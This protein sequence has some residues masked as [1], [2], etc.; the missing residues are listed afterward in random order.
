MTLDE[1]LNRVINQISDATRE[2]NESMAGYYYQ[3]DQTLFRILSGD[4]NKRYRLEKIEDYT[5]YYEDDNNNQYIKVVQ[6]KYH[7][8]KVTNSKVYKP[9]LYGYISYLAFV[10]TNINVNFSMEILIG[11]DI[12]I[13]V[14]KTSSLEGIL[15]YAPFTDSY[16]EYRSKWRENFEGD[17]PRFID[18]Q[19]H[20]ENFM[21]SLSVTEGQNYN[22]LKREI[23]DL[24]KGIH[25]IPRVSEETYYSFYWNI[26]RDYAI[27]HAGEIITKE[28]L[29]DNVNREVDCFIATGDTAFFNSNNYNTYVQYKVAGLISIYIEDI[30]DNLEMSLT[31]YPE[32][33]EKVVKYKTLI[34]PLIQKLLLKHLDTRSKRKAFLDTVIPGSLINFTD[35]LDNE[36]DHFKEN[37]V[38]IESVLRKLAK[39]FDFMNIESVEE[40]ENILDTTKSLWKIKN[41]DERGEAILIAGLT[42]DPLQKAI[43]STLTRKYISLNEYS[44]VWY[45]YDIDLKCNNPLPYEIDV[46]YPNSS[47]KIISQDKR[48][49]YFRIECLKCLKTNNL[50]DH[51]DCNYIIKEECKFG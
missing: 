35:E 9:I 34:Y 32:M 13:E 38:Y 46:A 49:N 42:D 50:C 11:T 23:I 25:I 17:R 16:K 51:S 27:N 45:F 15:S 6:I 39:I 48:R 28:L 1:N 20:R 36:I 47:H 37:R 40:A 8:C 12:G 33:E 19:L 3:I 26:V 4:E 44:D 30:I 14:D 41:I 21:N 22:D 18:S 2:A 10:E 43:L 7:N 29:I 5:E 24:I 31:H